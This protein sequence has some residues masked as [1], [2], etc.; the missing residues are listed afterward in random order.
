MKAKKL[1]CCDKRGDKEIGL[2]AGIAA[3]A[4]IRPA[5][6]HHQQVIIILG[7]NVSLYG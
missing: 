2:T 7:V 3:V 5:L 4:A 6:Y 1:V